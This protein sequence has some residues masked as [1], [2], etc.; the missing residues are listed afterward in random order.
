[1]HEGIYHVIG[2]ARASRFHRCLA[3]DYPSLVDSERALAA[4][5]IDRATSD[6]IARA[7]ARGRMPA[8]HS[9][10]GGYLGF[11]GEGARWRGDSAGLDWTQGCVGMSDANMDFLVKHT[12]DGTPVEIVP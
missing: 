2:R 12:R 4:G 10:L 5:L 1:M 11:H 3:I 9:A 8:Q 6:A 7:H